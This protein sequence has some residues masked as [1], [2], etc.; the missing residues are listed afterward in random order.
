MSNVTNTILTATTASS[1][2]SSLLSLRAG[3]TLRL[4]VAS[5]DGNGNYT[6]Q[7]GSLKLSV[8]SSSPLLLGAELTLQ[9]QQSQN[10]FT[11]H[12]TSVDSKTALN[13]ELMQSI[14]SSSS[15]ETETSATES[16]GSPL[17]R[18]RDHIRMAANFSLSVNRQAITEASSNLTETLVVSVQEDGSLQVQ[19][20]SGQTLDAQAVAIPA[21]VT[22][23]SAQVLQEPAPDYREQPATGSTMASSGAGTT[24]PVAQVVNAALQSSVADAAAMSMPE[25]ISGL[26]EMIPEQIVLEAVLPDGTTAYVRIDPARAAELLA[27][28]EAAQNSGESPDAIILTPTEKA[29]VWN[30]VLEQVPVQINL[31]SQLAQEGAVLPLTVQ[32]QALICGSVTI[33]PEVP[34]VEDLRQALQSIN[35]IPTRIALAAADALQQQGVA[36]SRENISILAQ[37]ATAAPEQAREGLLLAS[38]QLIAHDIPVSPSLAAGLANLPEAAA[39]F[40]ASSGELAETIQQSISSMT[41]NIVDALTQGQIITSQNSADPIQTATVSTMADG[42]KAALSSLQQL[43]VALDTET[44]PEAL[45]TYFQAFGREM[46]ASALDGV[47]SMASSR[48]SQLPLMQKLDAA[49]TALMP[50]VF[51]AEPETPAV[52]QQQSP[53]ATTISAQQTTVSSQPATTDPNSA[54]QMG[55]PS[56]QAAGARLPGLLSSDTAALFRQMVE[57]VQG[58]SVV[59]GSV[60]GAGSASASFTAATGAELLAESS[61]LLSDAAPAQATTAGSSKE[62]MQQVINRVLREILQAQS[63]EQAADAAK[64]AAHDPNVRQELVHLL[65]EM[66]RDAAA[67]DPVLRRLSEAASGLRDLGRRAMAQKAEYLASMTTKDAPVL[68]AEVPFRFP[69]GDGGSGTLSLYYRRNRKNNYQ[70]RV[71]L[72]LNTEA[73]GTVWGDLRDLGND[74][75]DMTFILESEESRDWLASESDTLVD[76]LKEKGFQSQPRFG[77]R[78]RQMEKKTTAASAFGADAPAGIDPEMQ[79]AGDAVTEKD[80]TIEPHLDVR[81]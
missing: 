30:A 74:N 46:L 13:A 58:G 18:G 34:T 5:S 54:A 44:T 42:A 45:G 69:T 78:D 26:V 3:Q 77:V 4:R 48:L 38:A 20:T 14:E 55:M 40:R 57:S 53:A 43:S 2:S 39:G 1:N 60:S 76:A 10:G 70:A 19:V 32:D 16:T 31:P 68:A 11:L 66:E 79:A 17:T 64:R 71:V 12:P 61:Q 23:A 24:T 28:V 22:D 63:P 36:I 75:L 27:Q 29:G 33:T 6:L 80:D 50:E 8:T 65:Q 81:I 41:K 59:S 51:S 9:V 49:V 7:Q 25:V 47:E 21:E 72:D 37:I 56:Q 62:P 52:S 15:S 35:V 73:L 67:H